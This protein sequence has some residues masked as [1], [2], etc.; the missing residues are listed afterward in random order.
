MGDVYVVTAFPPWPTR[1][2]ANFVTSHLLNLKAH[3][4]CIH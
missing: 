2:V 1:W 3:R 4:K